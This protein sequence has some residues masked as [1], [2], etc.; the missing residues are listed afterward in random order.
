MNW[1][2]FGKYS[3]FPSYHF[4]PEGTGVSPWRWL[5]EQLI[6]IQISVLFL[7]PMVFSS[8]I[9]GLWTLQWQMSMT[10]E[11]NVMLDFRLVLEEQLH[12]TD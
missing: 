2:P 4:S 6:G 7:E 12:T 3:V 9:L 10:A 11:V 8:V 5:K 1:S